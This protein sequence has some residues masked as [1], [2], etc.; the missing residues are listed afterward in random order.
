MVFRFRA[1]ISEVGHNTQ[2]KKGEFSDDNENSPL[3]FYFVTGVAAT[4]VSN[5]RIPLYG[6]EFRSTSILSQ[7]V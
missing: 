6:L 7:L 3:V 1:G 2:Q 5:N 4:D